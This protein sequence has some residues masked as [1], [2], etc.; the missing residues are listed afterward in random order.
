MNTL[1]IEVMQNEKN[2]RF[3]HSG[4]NS[5]FEMFRGVYIERSEYAQ[6]NSCI[7][8]VNLISYFV[9]VSLFLHY[10]SSLGTL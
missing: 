10:F 5:H 9:R 8:S 4:Y 3:C 6:Q 1:V 2:S 7:T